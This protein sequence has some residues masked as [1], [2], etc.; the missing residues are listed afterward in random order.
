[1]VAPTIGFI[2]KPFQASVSLGDRPAPKYKN[3]APVAGGG[4]AYVRDYLAAY[5]KVTTWA[6]GQV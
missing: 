6:R 2:D 1:M 3:A 5:R 4:I